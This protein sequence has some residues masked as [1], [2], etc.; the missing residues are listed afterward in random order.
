[1]RPVP[2]VELLRIGR[3]IADLDSDSFETRE[4]STAELADLVLKQANA[5]AV[6][7]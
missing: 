7:A 3:L 2:K 5:P 1:L 4:K 6:R